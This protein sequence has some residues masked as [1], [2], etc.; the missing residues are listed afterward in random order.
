M[1]ARLGG[2]LANTWCV[3]DLIKSVTPRWTPINT[4]PA[5]GIQDTALYMLF[6]PCKGSG[7]VVVA[8]MKPCRESSLRLSSGSSLR[9]RRALVSL[10]FFI[11]FES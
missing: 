8:Q 4:P 1:Q 5:D 3:T 10:P 6:S 2:Q 9:D 11:D 7:L